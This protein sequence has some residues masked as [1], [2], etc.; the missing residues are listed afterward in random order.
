[1]WF[2]CELTSF[3]NCFSDVKVSRNFDPQSRPQIRCASL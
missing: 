2:I 1:V 3:N